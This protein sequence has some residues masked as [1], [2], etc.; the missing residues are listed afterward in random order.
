MAIKTISQFDAATPASNDKI[1]FEQNGEGKSTT[2]KNLTL[3]QIYQTR[4]EFTVVVTANTLTTT[5]IDYNSF[6]IDT[7]KILAWQLTWS[8]SSS[9]NPIVVIQYL[10]NKHLKSVVHN[11]DR[12]QNVN[13]KLVLLMRY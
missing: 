4:L 11:W 10:D 6:G 1:L 5:I 2:I 13:F 9:D 8:N 3:A 7:S 12:A